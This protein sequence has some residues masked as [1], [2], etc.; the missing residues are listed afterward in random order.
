MLYKLIIV[1]HTEG[2]LVCWVDDV[3]KGNLKIST[4]TIH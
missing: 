2:E 1:T 3:A 4:H